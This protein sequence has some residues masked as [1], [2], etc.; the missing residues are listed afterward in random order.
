MEQ[1]SANEYNLWANECAKN[2]D[3]ASKQ[4]FEGLVTDEELH[5]DRFDTE[6]ENL[7]KFGDR[8]LALQSIERSKAVSSNRPTE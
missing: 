3:S 2:A 5:Y 7:E 4:I 1:E 8:Y 6:T